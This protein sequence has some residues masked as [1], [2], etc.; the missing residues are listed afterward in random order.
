MNV[1]ARFTASSGNSRPQYVATISIELFNSTNI[2]L[3]TYIH[4]IAITNIPTFLFFFFDEI[5][6]HLQKTIC[7]HA[8]AI[9]NANYILFDSC[10]RDVSEEVSERRGLPDLVIG[11]MYSPTTPRE[12]TVVDGVQ[13]IIAS[14]PA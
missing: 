4:A 12:V 11:T 10:I 6:T 7:V 8:Y 14:P 5:A 13:L 1:E 3:S 2:V 9:G